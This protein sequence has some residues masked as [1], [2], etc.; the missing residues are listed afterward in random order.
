M[1]SSVKKTWALPL[2][3]SHPQNRQNT[4]WSKNWELYQPANRQLVLVLLEAIQLQH[5]LPDKRISSHTTAPLRPQILTSDVNFS[6]QVVLP[7]LLANCQ[8]GS[9][10]PFLDYLLIF[11]AGHRIQGDAIRKNIA[12]N[13]DEETHRVRC[14][15]GGMELPCL[16]GCVLLQELHVFSYLKA[17][18]IASLWGLQLPDPLVYKKIFITGKCPRILVLC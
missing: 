1:S 8:S 16:L 15:G 5:H 18:E 7:A 3:L 6:P 4:L 13:S 10:N 2:L 17:L 9:L 12:K 14:V 11:K